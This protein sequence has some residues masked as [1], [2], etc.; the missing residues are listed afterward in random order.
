VSRTH[1]YYYYYYYYFR[2][3]GEGI[4]DDGGDAILW[5]RFCSTVPGGRAEYSAA[6]DAAATAA[7]GSFGIPAG[8]RARPGHSITAMGFSFSFQS[9]RCTGTPARY[10]H[11]VTAADHTAAAA[12]SPAAVFLARALCSP[13]VLFIARALA[14]RPS[15]VRRPLVKGPAPSPHTHRAPAP[16]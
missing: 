4:A 10:H 6:D 16:P 9:E 11:A 15:P 1:Y 8:K 3:G 5:V 7:A 13:L 2:G 14:P 12:T